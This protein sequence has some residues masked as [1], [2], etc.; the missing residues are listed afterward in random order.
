MGVL[1][2]ALVWAVF[3]GIALWLPIR[4]GP[5][6]FGVFVL[7]MAVNEVPLVLLV[8]FALSVTV[9]LADPSVRE[10]PAAAGIAV[11]CV[12][13][14][15]LIWLQVR[16]RTTRPALEAALADELGPDW[17]KSIVPP[18][19][20]PTGTRSP[21]LAGIFLPFQRRTRGVERIRN[22]PY[23][24]GG[25]THLLDLYRRRGDESARPILIHLHGGGFVQGNKSR[26]SVVLLNQLASNGWV[27]LSANYRLRAQSRFPNPVIDTKRVITWARAH[28]AE[29]GADPT[30]IFLVGGSA[31]GHLALS[32]ALTANDPRYQPGFEDTETSV[33]GAVAL[34]GYLGTLSSDAGSSPASL[35][36]RDAPPILIIHGARDTAVLP[37]G[38]RS[39]AATLRAES[40]S[41]VVYAELPDTQHDFDFFA[42]VRARVTAQAVEDF[43][44]WTRTTAC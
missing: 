27:C 2:T 11:S 33:H 43:L 7:T 28:A 34:Y 32:A 15:A 22:L 21:W 19:A 16:A 9:G 35:A 36:R 3:V 38:P 1:V 31:G 6:G 26:E 25:R 29:Y 24:P 18:P 10:G 44:A 40:Q 17:R 30:Q 42:S 39:V 4:G 12:V 23:A 41:P 20:R 14:L 37:E 8:V 13:A 5:V